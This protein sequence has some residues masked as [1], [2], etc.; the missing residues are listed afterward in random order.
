MFFFSI[1]VR[2]ESNPDCADRQPPDHPLHVSRGHSIRPQVQRN[3]AIRLSTVRPVCHL[4]HSGNT[5]R[6]ARHERQ[7]ARGGLT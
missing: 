6:S 7:L 2:I 1:P 3:S 4:P 5:D